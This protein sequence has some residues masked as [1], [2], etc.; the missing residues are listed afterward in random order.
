MSLVKSETEN[1]FIVS[2]PEA[3]EGRGG[4]SLREDF[5]VMIFI[6]AI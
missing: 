4:G 5:A 6:K 1:D 2:Y 3:E